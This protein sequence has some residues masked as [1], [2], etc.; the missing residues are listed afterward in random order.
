MVAPWRSIFADLGFVAP[1]VAISVAVTLAVT[2]MSRR[3]WSTPTS[4]LISAVLTVAGLA[5]VHGAAIAELPSNLIQGW[6]A[7]ASTGL[8]IPTDAAL[9]VPPVVIAALGSWVG[10][11]AIIRRR[12]SAPGVLGLLAAHAAVA[13][14]TIS[15]WQ[16]TWWF[17]AALAAVV[18]FLL[19]VSGL[20][21]HC[22][23]K[24]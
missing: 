4:F 5:A 7:L 6:K 3:G 24:N 11:E 13:A 21:R 9:V 2:L 12:F 15:Q 8:L 18:G 20:L 23:R 10:A 16:P 19:A 14:Y 22:N 17:A 1:M